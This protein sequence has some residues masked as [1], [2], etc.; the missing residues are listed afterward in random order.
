MQQIISENTNRFH[1][2]TDMGINTSRVPIIVKSKANYINALF[3]YQI[4][5]LKWK[6]KIFT[7]ALNQLKNGWNLLL[8]IVLIFSLQ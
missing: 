3:H 6:K 7:Q 5:L 1:T 8:N 2:L 4:H